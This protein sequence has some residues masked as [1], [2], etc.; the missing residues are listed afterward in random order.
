MYHRFSQF[1]TRNPAKYQR[2]SS[3]GTCGLTIVVCSAMATISLLGCFVSRA[4]CVEA[5][6]PGA[7]FCAKDSSP[8]EKLAAKEVRR[9]V[10]L[11]SATLLPIV[12]DLKAAGGG[13]IVIGAKD[14]PAIQT[15]LTDPELKAAASSMAAEQYMLKTVQHD[16]RTMLLIVGGDPIGTL[17][18]AYAFAEKLGVR[19]Y[20]HGDVIPDKQ[21]V[22][23]IP[24]LDDTHRPLFALRGL[25]A[26]SG[27]SRR[28]R[29]VD[30]GRLEGVCESNRQNADE[31]YR[32]SHLSDFKPR[33]GS[34]T[35]GLDWA[36]AGLQPRRHGED[37]RFHLLA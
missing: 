18:G 20:L 31:F 21:I 28:A 11:H 7:V 15:L 14:R 13:W 16:G 24:K 32:A 3:P 12:N 4:A 2:M 26:V 22:F 27:L 23:A 34:G 8:A 17:Y 6:E 33:S 25:A 35:D 37:K 19:F 29:L 36:A 9:Y 5:I 1:K 10:Y 30:N